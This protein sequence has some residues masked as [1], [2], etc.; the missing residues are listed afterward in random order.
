MMAAGEDDQVTVWDLALEADSTEE[1]PG[2]P[3]QLLFVHMG[4]REIK[5]VNLKIC[6]FEFDFRYRKLGEVVG[7]LFK[8]SHKTKKSAGRKR[9]LCSYHSFFF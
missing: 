3:P 8:T 4:Q 5:E 1:I 9:W 2:V 6:R 7:I